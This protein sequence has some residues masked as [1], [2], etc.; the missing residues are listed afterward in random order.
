M[1]G[2]SVGASGFFGIKWAVR[3]FRVNAELLAPYQIRDLTDE[4]ISSVL[5]VCLGG[6]IPLYVSGLPVSQLS[7]VDAPYY[8]RWIVRLHYYDGRLG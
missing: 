4:Y 2:R 3:K 8:E 6:G 5:S 7:P 1:P